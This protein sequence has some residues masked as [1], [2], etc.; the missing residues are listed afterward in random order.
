MRQASRDYQRFVTGAE[1]GMVYKVNGVKFD[2]Y[3]DGVLIEANG[4]EI[5]WYFNDEMS[6]NAVKDLFRTEGITGI[7][8]LFKPM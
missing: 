2:G 6:L 8:L 1:D 5:H 3:K 7:E 4:T